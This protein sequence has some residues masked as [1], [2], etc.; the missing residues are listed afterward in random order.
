MAYITMLSGMWMYALGNATMNQI[1]TLGVLSRLIAALAMPELSDDIYRFIWDGLVS[2]NGL[3]PYEYTPREIIL[4]GE[5]QLAPGSITLFP[6]LNSPDYHT[7]Y[8]PVIQAFNLSAVWISGGDIQGSA[9]YMKLVSAL[10]DTGSIMILAR[11]L[12]QCNITNQ[13][14]LA[15]FALNP[16][17][18]LEVS[19]NGHHEGFILFFLLTMIYNLMKSRNFIGGIMLGA[20]IGVKLTPV[21]L[22]PT[23]IAFLIRKGGSGRFIAGTCIS[24]G[25]LLFPLADP[26]VRNAILKSTW[27]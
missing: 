25:I 9:I 18:I 6:L 17:L 1:I 26:I 20:A 24:A 23:I 16:L 2:S 21:I 12:I 27:L 14:R 4:M 10:A 11:I 15:L 22:V 3:N 8:P 13:L 19:A 7:V 5:G